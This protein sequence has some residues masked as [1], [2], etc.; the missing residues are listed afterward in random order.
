MIHRLMTVSFTYSY[1]VMLL[2]WIAGWAMGHFGN[3]LTFCILIS[4]FTA[5][6]V[7]EIMR[8]KP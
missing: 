3:W 4:A 8:T 5:G 6:A 7:I 2:I 1:P